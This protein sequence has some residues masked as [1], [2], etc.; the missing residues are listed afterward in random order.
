[1]FPISELSGMQT[2]SRAPLK[3]VH[4]SGRAQPLSQGLSIIEELPRFAEREY[5]T[6]I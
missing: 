2:S 4:N 1:M 5:I 3:S 6:H